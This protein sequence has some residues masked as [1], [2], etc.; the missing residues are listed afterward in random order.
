MR[1]EHKVEQRQL[2]TQIGDLFEKH[3]QYVADDCQCDLCKKVGQLGERLAELEEKSDEK[4]GRNKVY[5][6]SP[7]EFLAL[8]ETMKDADIAELWD[9]T[10]P[11]L[12]A[13]KKRHKLHS[14]KKGITKEQKAKLLVE[15]PARQANDETIADIAREYGITPNTLTKLIA[16]SA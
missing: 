7:E 16:R 2:I 3:T 15:L 1:A 5:Q 13:F 10:H 6:Y 8:S 4:A 11:Q 12:K 14:V 9:V